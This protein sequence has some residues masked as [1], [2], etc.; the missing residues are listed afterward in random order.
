MTSKEYAVSQVSKAKLQKLIE[1]DSYRKLH[2]RVFH[3]KYLM[4]SGSK[5]VWD[6]IRIDKKVAFIISTKDVARR[7][8]K[9]EL[10]KFV[11]N[12][13]QSKL[14]ISAGLLLDLDPLKKAL[15]EHTNNFVCPA[16]GCNLD[17]DMEYNSGVE[18]VDTRTGKRRMDFSKEKSIRDTKKQKKAQE[19]IVASATGYTVKLDEARRKKIDDCLKF[20]NTSDEKLHALNK[21]IIS[22]DQWASPVTHGRLRELQLI[23]TRI[24]ALCNELKL[25]GEC[26]DFPGF[27]ETMYAFEEMF[28]S[29]F[30][31]I[32]I[33]VQHTSNAK[34]AY[35]PQLLKLHKGANA[36]NKK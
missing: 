23:R 11:I 25:K 30:A 26:V 34:K 22:L 5:K 19:A 1:T 20:L 29:K 18:A 4:D 35:A 10:E 16:Q 17:E 7:E 27:I 33:Q 3:H 2:N 8:L 32:D 21:D 28:N 13:L 12:E 24:Q 9:D 31:C 15:R 36:A 14:M 6:K